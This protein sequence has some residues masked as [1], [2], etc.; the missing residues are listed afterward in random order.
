MRAE[1]GDRDDRG[2]MN[3]GEGVCVVMNG[4]TSLILGRR[5][6]E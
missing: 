4:G 5:C 1:D 6:E 3:E 2:R